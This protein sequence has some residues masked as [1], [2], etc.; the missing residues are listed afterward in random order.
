MIKASI[1]LQDL[2][3]EMMEKSKSEI[4]SNVE[5]MIKAPEEKPLEKVI[6]AN[7]IRENRL[8]GIKGGLWET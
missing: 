4:I 8:S 3:R 1:C 2:R 7:R 6:T 5:K